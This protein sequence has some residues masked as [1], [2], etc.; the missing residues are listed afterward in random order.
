MTRRM[1]K[2]QP[3]IFYY[4]SIQYRNRKQL[5]VCLGAEVGEGF[6]R[7]SDAEGGHPGARKRKGWYEEIDR[8]SSIYIQDV[9]T[10]GWAKFKNFKLCD[11]YSRKFPR[12][13]LCGLK[14]NISTPS[15]WRN[16]NMSFKGAGSDYFTPCWKQ[17]NNV[18]LNFVNF[19]TVW[20]SSEDSILLD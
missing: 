10:T 15:F 9:Y 17:T 2:R 11:K 13:L 16:I 6:C 19:Q 7:I 18:A 4:F 20:P 5:Q 8:M 14:R 3:I 12:G 1:S